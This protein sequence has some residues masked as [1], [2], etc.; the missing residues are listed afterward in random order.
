LWLIASLFLRRYQSAL[1]LIDE[2]ET[3]LTVFSELNTDKNSF[4]KKENEEESVVNET[5]MKIDTEDKLAVD[6][7]HQ[8]AAT[9]ATTTNDKTKAIENARRLLYTAVANLMNLSPGM[10]LSCSFFE[11]ENSRIQVFFLQSCQICFRIL[12]NLCLKIQQ[13]DN[14]HRMERI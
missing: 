13:M 4:N 14:V 8:A 7:D 10:L 5:D 2:L 6:V 3:A 11:K 1:P 12:W 9:T